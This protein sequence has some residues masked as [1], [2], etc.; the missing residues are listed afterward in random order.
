MVGKKTNHL[1]PKKKKKKIATRR[2]EKERPRNRVAENGEG[3]R[4][5]DQKLQ[6]AIKNEKM[7]LTSR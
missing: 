7:S 2:K 1:I 5:R 6:F 4:L 3:E